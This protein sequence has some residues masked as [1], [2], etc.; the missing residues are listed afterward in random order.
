MTAIKPLEVAKLAREALDRKKGIDI[1]LLDLQKLSDV[2]DY[3]LVVSGSSPPHLKALMS[4][5]QHTMKAAGLLS[6]RRA[7]SPE[8]GWMVLDYVDVVIHIFLPPLRTYYAVEELWDRAPA[9][10]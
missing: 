9:I 5:V 8:S 3:T 4:E 2:T 7:G 1:R 10:D 6:H